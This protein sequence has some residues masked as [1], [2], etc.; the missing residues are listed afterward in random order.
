MKAHS[1]GINGR[2]VSKKGIYLGLHIILRGN[3]VKEV[4]DD[5]EVEINAECISG[6]CYSTAYH[7][8]REHGANSVL[9]VPNTGM[10]ATGIAGQGYDGE[11]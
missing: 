4:F 1:G 8:I 9:L 3:D 5:T 2:I 6:Q 7:P 10:V 11:P